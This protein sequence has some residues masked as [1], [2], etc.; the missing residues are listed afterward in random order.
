MS[1]AGRLHVG[2]HPGLHNEDLYQIT[3]RNN[4]KCNVNE[5]IC[6]LF[7]S[8]K[9]SLNLPGISKPYPR[10]GFSQMDSILGASEKML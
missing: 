10:A 8:L 1:E 7:N 5:T 2:E 9:K 3:Q 6:T 4:Y